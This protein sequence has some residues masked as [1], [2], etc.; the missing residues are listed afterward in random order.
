MCLYDLYKTKEWGETFWVLRAPMC[1]PIGR[2][3]TKA[4][5]MKDVKRYGL[6][7]YK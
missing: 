5:A 1:S 4:E 6:R 7:L 3:K 2:Y